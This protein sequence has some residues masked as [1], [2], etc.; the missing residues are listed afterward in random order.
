MENENIE[1]IEEVEEDENTESTISAEPQKTENISENDIDEA[2][3]DNQISIDERITPE[4]IQ[5]LKDELQL[6]N[7]QLKNINEIMNDT[8]ITEYEMQQLQLLQDLT[9]PESIIEPSETEII[10]QDVQFYSNL[11]II[12]I[13]SLITIAMTWRFVHSVFSTFTRHIG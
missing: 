2:H 8:S 1:D 13:L 7:S 3:N 9:Q 12:V 5:E 4:Q 6:I 11:S 10:Y